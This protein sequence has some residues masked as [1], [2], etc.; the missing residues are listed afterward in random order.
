[1]L[2][3]KARGA[4]EEISDRWGVIFHHGGCSRNCMLQQIRG[5]QCSACNSPLGRNAIEA[6]LAD[7]DSY[8]SHSAIKS[9]LR[10]QCTLT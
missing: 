4:F 3:S 7:S 6:A 9:S 10:Q 5:L 8:M 1:M 2:V